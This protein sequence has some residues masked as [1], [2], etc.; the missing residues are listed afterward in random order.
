MLA[1]DVP[2]VLMTRVYSRVRHPSAYASRVRCRWGRL[3]AAATLCLGGGGLWAQTSNAPAQLTTQGST[4][5]SALPPSGPQI[6]SV[7]LYAVYYSSSVPE[8]GSTL[9]VNSANLSSAVG[10]GGSIVFGWLK[11]TQRTTFSLSYTPSYTAQ[12]QYTSLNALNHAFSMNIARKLSPRWRLGFSAA[13]NYSTIT[14]S[15]FAPT[16]LSNVA[17]VPSTSSQFSGALLSGNFTGNQQLGVA[18]TN[19]PLV[20][21]PLANLLYGQQVFTS[22]AQSTLS[23]SISPRLSVTLTGGGGRTQYISQN[24]ATT[25][26]TP[27]VLSNTTSGT[28]GATLSYSLSPVTQL[29]GTV[30]TNRISSSLIDAYTTTSLATFGRTLGQQ[31]VLQLH[32][33]VGFT[34]PVG[35]N[36]YAVPTKPLPAAG[37]SLAFKSTSHTLLGS[38]DHSVSDSYGLGSSSNSTATVAWRWRRYG[39]RWSLQ[40]SLSWQ[41][42][43]GNAVVNTSGWRATAGLNREFGPHLSMLWQYTY[44]KYSGGLETS[45]YS[46]SESAVRVSMIWTPQPNIPR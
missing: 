37:G 45:V 33:G 7:S 8:T 38:I 12:T 26:G 29:G 3:V 21:S 13:A 30:T 16:E 2:G 14:E 24:Q 41:Q 43:Q 42:L 36:Y 34:N 28:A 44:L 25:P 4:T 1:N 27:P 15:L 6:L 9:Q 31:W 35:Q 17:A 23:Y 32:G 5:P 10:G 46:F 18:L 19:S 20:E 40:S 11:F 22:S 39:S